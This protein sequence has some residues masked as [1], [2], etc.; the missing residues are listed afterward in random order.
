LKA[1]QK[2]LCGHFLQLFVSNPSDRKQGCQMVYFRTKNSNLGKFWRALKWN[3]LDYVMAVWD[4]LGQL[5]IFMAI[6]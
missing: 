5:D 1:F 6:W 3:M 4:K 2:F